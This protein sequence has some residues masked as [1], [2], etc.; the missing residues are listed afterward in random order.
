VLRTSSKHDLTDALMDSLL[1]LTRTHAHAHAHTNTHTQ[2]GHVNAEGDGM[3]RAA[4]LHLVRAV[5]LGYRESCVVRF[6]C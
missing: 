3:S 4:F 5:F 1:K 6:R 2:G